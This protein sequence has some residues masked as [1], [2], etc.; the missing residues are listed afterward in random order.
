MT[1]ERRWPIAAVLPSVEAPMRARLRAL[2]DLATLAPSVRNSQPWRIAI[3]DDDAVLVRLDRGRI[4]A[5]ADPEGRAATTSCGALLGC[6]EVALRA[7]GFEVA[8]DRLP[9]RGDPDLIAR[10][11]VVGSRPPAAEETW[12]FQALPKRRTQRGE[13]AAQAIAPALMGRLT[14]LAGA[15]GVELVAVDDPAARRLLAESIARGDQLQR[16][17]PAYRDELA[18][19]VVGDPPITPGTEIGAGIPAHADEVPA[20]R[21]GEPTRLRTF[22]VQVPEDRSEGTGAGE[23]AA[24]GDAGAGDDRSS[25]TSD[26]GDNAPWIP[27]TERPPNDAEPL[28]LLDLRAGGPAAG[29]D[30]GVDDGSW[31]HRLRPAR[32]P[33]RANLEVTFHGTVDAGERLAP[34]VDAAAIDAGTPRFV[35]LVTDGDGPRQ[36]IQTGEA[37]ARILLRGR[38]DH[39]LASFFGQPIEVASLRAELRR[40]LDLPGAPQLVLR[41]GHAGD[42]RA[43]PRRALDDLLSEP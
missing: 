34:A 13:M 14:A 16:A 19:A 9:E 6:L 36:W 31:V 20:I 37:L 21:A 39:V 15:Q 24:A 29:A 10:V 35:V 1:P 5:V 41:L 26:P 30:G 42:A 38:V 3:D 22:G 43:T 27:D 33:R 2:V 18:A 23:V 11:R 7:A 4:L 12:M 32:E 40:A 28:D 25:E 17:D 8:I